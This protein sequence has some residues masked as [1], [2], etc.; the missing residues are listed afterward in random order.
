MNNTDPIADM[1]TRIRNGI[2]VKKKEVS[3]PYSRIKEEI[4][5]VIKKEGYI[6]GFRLEKEFP[7]KLVAE[8]KYGKKRGVNVIEGLKKISKPGRRV[9][10]DVDNIP[11]VLG[12]MGVAVISTSKG[13]LSGKECEKQNVGGEV[14]FHIW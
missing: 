14:L 11:R 3:I 13:I 7:K 5:K 12:G 9:Y 2:G 8:L 10:S 4:L 6:S 1:L